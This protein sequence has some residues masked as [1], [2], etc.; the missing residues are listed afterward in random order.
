MLKV[1]FFSNSLHHSLIGDPS[2]V[3]H[4]LIDECLVYDDFSLTDI[5]LLNNSPEESSTRARASRACDGMQSTAR[6]YIEPSR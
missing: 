4:Y 6:P 1:I 5:E 2:N 3:I